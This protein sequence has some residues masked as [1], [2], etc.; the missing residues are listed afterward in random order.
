MQFLYATGDEY[1][2]MDTDT[3]EQLTFEKQQL[4][5]NADLLKENMN[6]KI[7]I[8]EHRPIDV[9]LPITQA[10]EGFARM[11]EGRTAGKIV[12]TL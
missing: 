3:Y 9:E 4:G 10:R 8:Y 1:T 11:L 6:V 2:F 7:L 12:F 5:D